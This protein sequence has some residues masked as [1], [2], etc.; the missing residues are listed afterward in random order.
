MKDSESLRGHGLCFR[1]GCGAS[2]PLSFLPPP[3]SPKPQERGSGGSSNGLCTRT[4]GLYTRNT[5]GWREKGGGEKERAALCVMEKPTLGGCDDDC[6][7]CSSS[8]T[9]Y[10]SF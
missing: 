3:S 10:E 5:G 7:Y 1:L 8:V 2:I 4:T 6:V 9:L